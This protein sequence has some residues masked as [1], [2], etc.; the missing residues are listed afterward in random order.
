MSRGAAFKKR[1]LESGGRHTYFCLAPLFRPGLC[2]CRIRPNGTTTT[3]G[4]SQLEQSFDIEYDALDVDMSLTLSTII[5]EV[6]H[7]LHND[8]K[9]INKSN[10]PNGA[11]TALTLPVEWL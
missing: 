11:P 1:P 2:S 3:S 7:E 10:C 9:N 6:R 5:S 8:T 4:E